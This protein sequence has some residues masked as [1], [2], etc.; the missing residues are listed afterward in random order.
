MLKSAP[1]TCAAVGRLVVE[2]IAQFSSVARPLFAL[3]LGKV[4][5]RDFGADA[6]QR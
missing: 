3:P 4:K 1:F 6:E 5:R 2:F